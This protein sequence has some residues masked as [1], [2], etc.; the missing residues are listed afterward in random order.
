MIFKCDTQCLGL[1]HLHNRNLRLPGDYGPG[2]EKQRDV[3]GRGYITPCLPV[4]SHSHRC[5]AT[6]TLQ[7][8]PR[9]TMAISCAQTPSWP[10]LLHPSGWLSPCGH[11]APPRR[12]SQTLN[13]TSCGA[14][15]TESNTPQ[16]RHCWKSNPVPQASSW[17]F[18]Y[19][20]HQ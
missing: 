19:Q 20:S 14:T 16:P 15:D 4:P 18:H 7:L 13:I 10:G 8:G 6:C 2:L 12:Y 9:V 11:W 1:L 17:L 3:R 5:R